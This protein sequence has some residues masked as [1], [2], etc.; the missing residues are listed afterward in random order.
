MKQHTPKKL[1]LSKESVR[2]LTRARL[3]EVA[4]GINTTSQG[5]TC[6][7]CLVGCPSIPC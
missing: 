6:Q 1:Q 5:A 2:L 7:T 4:G 3:D